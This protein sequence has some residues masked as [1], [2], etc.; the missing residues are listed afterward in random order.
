MRLSTTGQIILD[1][2]VLIADPGHRHAW[3]PFD[4]AWLATKLND[5]LAK[6][7]SPELAFVTLAPG[8][9]GWTVAW[10]E[11]GEPGG[12]PPEVAVFDPA[13]EAPLSASDVRKRLPRPV[14]TALRALSKACLRLPLFAG[15]PD[16]AF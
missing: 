12:L 15:G 2:L 16:V 5:W 8:S 14:V 1:P 13:R 7:H 11:A 6:H 9:G 10:L 3:H 4:P